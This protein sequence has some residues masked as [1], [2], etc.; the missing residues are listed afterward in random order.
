MIKLTKMLPE[1]DQ[2]KSTINTLI[3]NQNEILARL[4][5]VEDDK[6]E[7]NVPECFCGEIHCGK[8]YN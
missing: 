4:E 5:K 7:E 2:Y 3:D 6:S 1:N 8:H